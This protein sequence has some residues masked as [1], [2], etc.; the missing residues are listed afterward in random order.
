MNVT[1]LE[2]TSIGYIFIKRRINNS[3]SQYKKL[4]Q[5]E[6]IKDRLLFE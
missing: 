2:Y 4:K 1:V 5:K 3:C 6:N